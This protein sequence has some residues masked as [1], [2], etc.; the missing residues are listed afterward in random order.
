MSFGP[1]VIEKAKEIQTVDAA[2]Q[3]EK[4]ERGGNLKDR[5]TK[6]RGLQRQ[7]SAATEQGERQA[8][9][10]FSVMSLGICT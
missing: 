8:K 2:Q 7:T 6:K 1:T 3:N 5:K 4:C 9:D 10:S